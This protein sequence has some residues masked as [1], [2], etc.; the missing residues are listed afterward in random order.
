MTVLGEQRP[1][2]WTKS[3]NNGVCMYTN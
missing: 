3:V 2:T 1:E